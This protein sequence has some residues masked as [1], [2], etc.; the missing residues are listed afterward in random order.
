[1]AE[2]NYNLIQK[3]LKVF[4]QL[5]YHQFA[6]SYN[7]VAWIVSAGQWKRWVS[8]TLPFLGIG[9]ILELGHG[10]GQLQIMARAVQLDFTG[11]D[12][13]PQ[14][15]KICKRRLQKS[16]FLPKLVTAAG[17]TLP[18]K[19]QSFATVVTTF[20]TDYILQTETLSEIHRVL[21]DQGR[22]VVLPLAWITGKGTIYKFAAWLFKITGQNPAPDHPGFQA[23]YQMIRD[24]GFILETHIIPLENSK[25]FIL[26]ARK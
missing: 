2:L 6:W 3:L 12:L 23:G 25:I 16:G 24:A 21:A 20:P 8:S 10:P 18:F 13:S 19:T 11:L 4:Y 14:M 7:L 9:K 5:L 1:M 17:S 26:V 22:L 15:G